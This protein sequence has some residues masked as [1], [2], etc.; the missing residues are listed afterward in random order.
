MASPTKPLDTGDPH[1]MDRRQL[2]GAVQALEAEN[3]AL[4]GRIG[5]LRPALLSL[6]HE[7]AAARREAAFLRAELKRSGAA[8]PT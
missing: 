8:R 4:V 1:Q 6:A 7:L 5:Q 3:R 2:E